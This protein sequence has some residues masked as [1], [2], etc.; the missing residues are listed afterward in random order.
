MATSATP[1]GKS[2]TSTRKRKIPPT[3]SNYMMITLDWSEKLVLPFDDGVIFLKSLE[4]AESY[5]DRTGE[6]GIT[7]YKSQ[8]RTE[9]LSR[10]E[11]ERY[12]M[13]HILGVDPNDLPK[14]FNVEAA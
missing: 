6:Q 11:Y 3:P 5:S 4:R 2:S 8:I 14:D 1:T 9:I 10:A 7:P 13:A 12:K